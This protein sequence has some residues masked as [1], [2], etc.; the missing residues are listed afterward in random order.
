MKFKKQDFT[1]NELPLLFQAFSKKLF[2]RPISGDISSITLDDGCTFYFTQD[3]YEALKLDILTAD[4]EGKFRESNAPLEWHNLMTV[5]LQA[6]SVDNF[7]QKSSTD[8][9]SETSMFWAA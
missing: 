1:R 5:F 3:Y 8:Y 7:D 4:K 9:F 2:V 6:K